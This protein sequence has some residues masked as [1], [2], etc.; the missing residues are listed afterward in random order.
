MTRGGLAWLEAAVCVAGTSRGRGSEVTFAIVG[1]QSR[2]D[3]RMGWKPEIRLSWRRQ[4]ASGHLQR[5]RTGGE[6]A[7]AG[8]GW[9]LA[10]GKQVGSFMQAWSARGAQVR[11]LGCSREASSSR[12]RKWDG[13]WGCA[14]FPC[15]QGTSRLLQMHGAMQVRCQGELGIAH[16]AMQSGQPVWGKFGG[17]RLCS[18]VC[19]ADHCVRKTKQK[20]GC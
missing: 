12:L 11:N 20:K 1:V 13:Q 9:L 14:P 7:F 18:L 15:N 10:G 2:R 6:L 4:L 8:I 3:F 17:C 5:E 16:S 19:K